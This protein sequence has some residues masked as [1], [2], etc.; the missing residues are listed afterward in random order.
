MKL[1][2]IYHNFLEVFGSIQQ[3]NE[4][5]L[6]ILLYVTKDSCG[7]KW[8]NVTKH[9]QIDTNSEY[10]FLLN[11]IYSLYKLYILHIRN[12]VTDNITVDL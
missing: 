9:K 6:P 7:I 2:K 11:Q 12:A 5:F 10:I 3:V 1:M 4:V 8:N